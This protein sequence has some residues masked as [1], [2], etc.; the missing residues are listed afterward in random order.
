M[1]SP[2]QPGPT[3]ALPSGH[4][5]RIVGQSAALSVMGLGI[6]L[7]LGAG[8]ALLPYI[9]DQSQ[10][11]PSAPVHHY[12][13]F[14]RPA[15][16]KQLLGF[17]PALDWVVLRET[18]PQVYGWLTLPQTDLSTP[19]VCAPANDPDFYLHHD[20]QG[21]RSSRGCPYL[22]AECLDEGSPK[23]FGVVY[24]HHMKDGTVFAPLASYQDEA[25]AR[26]HPSLL[27]HRPEATTTLEVWFVLV[28]SNG[29]APLSW[30]WTQ[31][32]LPKVIEELRGQASVVL[33]SDEPAAVQRL[34]CFVTCSYG[35]ANERTLVFAVEY[36]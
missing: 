18:M 9:Q 20:A 17:R 19:L 22:A 6:T 30:D 31:E 26:T 36:A 33:R 10:A 2:E 21:H 12:E 25:F 7:S 27:L 11:R 15:Q 3:S 16:T 35:R 32:D 4:P 23:P 29:S 5:L 8:L 28:A 13:L 24:G 14:S 34:W 1:K